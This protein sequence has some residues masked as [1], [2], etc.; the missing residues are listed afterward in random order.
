MTWYYLA[1]FVISSAMFGLTFGALW[2]Y[3][4]RERFRPDTL[5]ADLTR[6]STA[7][8]ITT[9]LALAVQMTLPLVIFP[10]VTTVLIWLEVTICLAVPFIFSGIVVS[11][12]LTRSP[13]PLG[14]VYC[15]DL[16][17][18]ACGCLSVLA[19]LNWTDGLSAVLWTSAIAVFGGVLFSASGGGHTSSHMGLLARILHK[20]GWILTIVVLCATL[21]GLGSARG[22]LNPILVKKEIELI[23]FARALLFEKW[24]SFSRVIVIGPGVPNQPIMWGASPKFSA[25]NWQVK[26]RWMNIDG[27]AA[28]VAYGIHGDIAQAEFLKYDITNLAYYLPNQHSA[29]IIGVGGGRDVMSARVFGIFDITGI[30]IKTV[31]SSDSQKTTVMCHNRL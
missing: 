22:R 28:T 30:E 3:L 6:F 26:Q 31:F 1:F 7:F 5:S 24:N 13:Y 11:L 4:Q 18:A 2:V 27:E 29:A 21:N 15:V 12:A 16:I 25:Q 10:S 14:K 9:A 17:G 19:L 8:G 20:P 23:K